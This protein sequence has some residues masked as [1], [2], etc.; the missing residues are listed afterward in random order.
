MP[1][2]RGNSDPGQPE[3]G[4]YP[5]GVLARQAGVSTRTVRYYEEIGLLRAL[6]RFAGGRRVFDGEAL[7]RLRFIG[8]LKTLG[9]SLAEISRLNEVFEM[10]YSTAEMLRVLEAQLGSHMVTIE[11][12]LRELGILRSDLISYRWRIQ[13]RLNGLRNEAGAAQRAGRG[14]KGKNR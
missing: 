4:Q 3:G 1:P 12:R 9:F 8:R 10:H 6:R 13:Q 7:S 2:S 5:I 11:G 14:K